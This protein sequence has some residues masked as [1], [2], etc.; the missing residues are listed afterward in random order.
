V[1]NV[2]RGSGQRAG[3]ERGGFDERATGEFVVHFCNLSWGIS[4]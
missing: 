4:F 2:K 1:Q 3:R